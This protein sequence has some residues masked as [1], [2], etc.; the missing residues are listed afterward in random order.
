MDISHYQL[1]RLCGRRVRVNDARPFDDR[2]EKTKGFDTFQGTDLPGETVR[3]TLLTI[4]LNP[5]HDRPRGAVDQMIVDTDFPVMI[6]A[7]A[8]RDHLVRS[9]E[10]RGQV[11]RRLCLSLLRVQIHLLTSPLP[12]HTL[13]LLEIH[14]ILH[15]LLL[16]VPIPH[17]TQL[18]PLLI[19]RL[20]KQA[21]IYKISVE[22]G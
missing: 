8:M 2:S 21:S 9:R 3:A 20:T 15:P 7:S 17:H 13:Q 18:N 19:S 11:K 12:L 1:L 10:K 14:V 4:Q 5:D 22:T 6:V 16:T